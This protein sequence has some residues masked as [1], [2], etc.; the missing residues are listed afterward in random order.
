ML[1][2]DC[3]FCKIIL[4]K[5]PSSI[6]LETTK[7][8]VIKDIQPKAPTHLLLLPKIHLQNMGNITEKNSAYIADL[9]L[10]VAEL[11]KN[12]SSDLG[13]NIISNNGSKAGQSVDHLHWH[14]LSGK[15]LYEGGFSL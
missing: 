5:I 6:I 3:V 13:F 14:F 4:K 8:L 12:F 2:A 10:C 1:A 9:G 15:N 11:S 7:T